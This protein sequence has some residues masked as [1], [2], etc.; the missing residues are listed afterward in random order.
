MVVYIFIFTGWSGVG[1]TSF[2]ERYW[3]LKESPGEYLVTDPGRVNMHVILGGKGN[4]TLPTLEDVERQ[5]WA[6]EVPQTMWACISSPGMEQSDFVISYH[7]FVESHY[8]KLN[9]KGQ[10]LLGTIERAKYYGW[11]WLLSETDY[12]RVKPK[13]KKEPKI[14]TRTGRHLKVYTNETV[15]R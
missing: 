13:A 6:W 12:P 9:R 5:L 15:T 14:R 7:R 3:Y 11:K 8:Q 2:V 1:F 10:L 4:P